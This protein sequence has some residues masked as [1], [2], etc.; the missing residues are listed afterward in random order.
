LIALSDLFDRFG[1]I[2]L[3]RRFSVDWRGY[4]AAISSGRPHADV[5]SVSPA[6]SATWWLF[7]QFRDSE[8][9]CVPYV[10]ETNYLSYKWLAVSYCDEFPNWGA[11]KL[12]VDISP[13]YCFLARRAVEAIA[14]THRDLR[15][16]II[17]R[18]PVERP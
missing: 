1:S 14:A 2:F 3:R 10:K 6:R 15:V 5:L 7:E 4:R 16:L 9:F 17:L 12:Y 13:N 8:A 18:E 11:G